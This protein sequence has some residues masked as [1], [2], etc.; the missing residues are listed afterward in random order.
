M[1]NKLLNSDVLIPFPLPLLSSVESRFPVY[2]PGAQRGS[3][4]LPG[5]SVLP[6]H[7][8]LL[9]DL[10]LV[11][12]PLSPDRLFEATELPSLPFTHL[13]GGATRFLLECEDEWL[14]AYEDE[15]EEVGGEARQAP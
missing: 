7:F 10:S 4:S 9:E 15:I 5:N 11:R 12:T 14:I 6:I 13:T 1:L 2:C 3:A 8:H